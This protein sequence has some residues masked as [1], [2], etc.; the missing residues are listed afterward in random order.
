MKKHI[1]F[2]LQLKRAFKS[3]PSILLVTVLTVMSIGLA[4]FAVIRENI[5]GDDKKAVVIG[6]VGDTEN[7]ILQIGLS[8]LK[9]FDSSRFFMD[10]QEM[11]E[12]EAQAKL[13]SGDIHGY[14][15]IPDDYIQNI[16]RG[17]NKPATFV[18]LSN[19]DNFGTILTTEVTKIVSDILTSTQ[20]SVYSMQEIVHNFSPGFKTAKLTDNLNFRYLDFVLHRQ[21]TYN[22]EILG[23]AD[24]ISMGAYYI[25]GMLL[26]F[27]LLWGISCNKFLG[28]ENLTLCRTLKI[29]GI[30][31]WYQV[32]A[33]YKAYFLLT[34]VMLIIF[35][36][37]FGIFV[38]YVST[39]I[40]ELENTGILSSVSFVLKALPVVIM[41]T[42]MHKALY[43]M[44]SGTVSIILLLFIVAVGMG[45]ISGCF[46][47]NNFFPPQV[48]NIAEILPSGV[49]FSYLR[50]LMSSSLQMWDFMPITI[51][52][53][54]FAALTVGVRKYRI[55]GDNQ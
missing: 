25:C 19:P 37:L 41:I 46:Y 2:W 32:F 27:L 36:S 29:R 53:F 45:Y 22:I 15:L 49:G 51:Y 6:V 13:H 14:V 48:R 23:I 24:R 50:K 17:K 21:N 4:G 1:Y 11:T 43:E 3:Y 47:P 26:F 8:A 40:P 31:P 54:A 33:E 28:A 34:L 10:F 5:N 20:V 16:W 18:T 38:K 44:V 39:G 12:N 42:V 52:T 9:S 35:A 55:A 30:K 7:S